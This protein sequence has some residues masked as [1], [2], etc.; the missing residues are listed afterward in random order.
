MNSNDDVRHTQEQRV[1][2]LIRP[3]L[4]GVMAT[5][6]PQGK[7]Q[8]AVVAFSQTDQLE[9]IVA[10]GSDT[11]KFINLSANPSVAMTI[12]WDDWV[13]VQYEGIGQILKDEEAERAKAI[14]I[15]KHPGSAEHANKP[16]ERYIHIKPSWIRYSDLSKHPAEVFE[17]RYAD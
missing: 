11:R 16:T 6:S 3:L 10:T 17:L 1:D 7:P 8:S 15:A 13:T 2:D 14:H 5:V 12:G 9:L 4:Y